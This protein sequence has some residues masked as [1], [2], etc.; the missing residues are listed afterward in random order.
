MYLK[1]LIY[2]YF[3]GETMSKISF[4]VYLNKREVFGAQVME[5]AKLIF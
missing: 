1:D 3:L 5:K 2:K 4:T